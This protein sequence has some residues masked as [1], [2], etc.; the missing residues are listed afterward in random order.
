MEIKIVKN[1]YGVTVYQV[2]DGDCIQEFW[3]KKEAQE[4]IDFFKK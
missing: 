2:R 4:F 1:E 3:T